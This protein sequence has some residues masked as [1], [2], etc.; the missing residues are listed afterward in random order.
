MRDT[1]ELDFLHFGI[2]SIDLQHQKFYNLLSEL[3]M[4]NLIGEDNKT[5]KEVIEELKVYCI[6]HFEMEN[7]IMK[8]IDFPDIVAHTKQH[9]MFIQK[10]EDFEM[11]Y[12]Y[13]SAALSDQM[14][15]F[16]QKWFLVH[17]PE[18]DAKYIEY[19]NQRKE[20]HE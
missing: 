19:I 16:L 4:Y 17:I 14:L 18:W 15:G 8:R 2:K 5:V 1:K 9:D 7:R 3:K 10:I 6:Y 20:H 12:N 13:Q 11:A